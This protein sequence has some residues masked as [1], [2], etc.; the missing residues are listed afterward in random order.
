MP[1]LVAERAEEGVL[2]ALSVSARSVSA[3]S[4]PV[5]WASAQSV[6]VRLVLALKASARRGRSVP[7]A[8]SAALVLA[9]SGL[10][11]HQARGSA[12]LA[13]VCELEADCPLGQV[14]CQEEYRLLVEI[15]PSECPGYPVHL[16]WRLANPASEAVQPSQ[17]LARP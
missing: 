6:Q 3:Q 13:W 1:V 10:L 9:L 11:V 5:R 4:V 7:P 12:V 16:N 14:S 17:T 8:V 15:P 2:K